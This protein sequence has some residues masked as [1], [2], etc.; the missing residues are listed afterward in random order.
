[1]SYAVVILAAGLA[2]R[3]GRPKQLLPAGGVAM[4]R[5]V[6]E[7]ACRTAADPVVVVT[8]AYGA[9][10]ARSVAGL[11]ASCV[12]NTHYETGSYS[13]LR[14]GLEAIAETQCPAVVLV[15]D[16][17]A[18]PTEVIEAVGRSL[19]QGSWGVL[20]DYSDGP[21]HPFGLSAEMISSLPETAPDRFI[22]DMLETD[23]RAERLTYQTSKPL[24]VNT[25]EDY[26]MLGEAEG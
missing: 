2:T 8:G 13:S 9:Q 22:F 6:V 26:E 20:T 23:E 18:I 11:C 15:A 3:M 19:E 12:E 17:P 24:D 5:R 10:V 1:M 14:T 4:V 7:A 21:G 25:P 16:M